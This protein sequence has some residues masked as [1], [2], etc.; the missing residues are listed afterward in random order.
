MTDIVDEQPRNDAGQF[1]APETINPPALDSYEPLAPEIEPEDVAVPSP[2]Q[3]EQQFGDGYLTESEKPEPLELKLYTDSTMTEETAPNVTVTV[4]QAG[5]LLSNYE[6]NVS[7]YV[8]ELDDNALLGDIDAA[9]ADLVA[10]DPKAAE[11]YGLDA[12]EVA[13]NAK[14]ELQPERPVERPAT[15]TR[16]DDENA[17]I[18]RALENPRIREFLESNLAQAEAA[19]QQ[20]VQALEGAN[21]AS[22]AR[23]NDLLKDTNIGQLP[24]VEAREAAFQ[25]LAR[26]NPALYIQAQ[27]EM[28]SIA[29]AQ[30]IQAQ[31]QQHQTAA[32]QRQFE[33]YKTQENAKFDAAV[34]KVSRA[35]VDAVNTYVSDVLKLSP[36][37][38]GQ[39]RFNPTA[40]DHRFQLALLH[41]AKWNAL[42][43]APR[44]RPTPQQVPNQRPSAGERA[45][46]KSRL[47]SKGALTEA[48]GWALLQERMR[49]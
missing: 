2:E 15:A 34:G 39:L 23:L 16:P 26:T 45:P 38:A 18:A 48:E 20:Y 4:E 33:A 17:E 36:E 6:A 3:F 5:Q 46:A 44:P 27:A 21:R 19:R 24:T 25:D 12:K 35:D 1:T 13:D 31:H 11:E 28:Q 29:N 43:S 37:E 42:Q 41:A 22:Y 47:E 30:G 49:G 9:R 8:N 14:V 40:V 7:T 32:Q 10:N